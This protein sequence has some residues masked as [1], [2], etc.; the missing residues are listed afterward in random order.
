MID[1]DITMKGEEYHP[2][3]WIIFM[4]I[5]TEMRTYDTLPQLRRDKE[6]KNRTGKKYQTTNKQYFQCSKYPSDSDIIFI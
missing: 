6:E 5:L 3:E 2:R 4:I 1:I